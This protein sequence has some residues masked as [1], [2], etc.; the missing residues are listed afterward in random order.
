[1]RRRRDIARRTYF[2]RVTLGEVGVDSGLMEF[3]DG[4]ALEL[5]DGSGNPIPD[6]E[7]ILHCA[8][9]SQK[10]GKLDREG[11]AQENNVPPGPVVVE[12]VEKK[13]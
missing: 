6:A 11:K 3:K 12:F 13:K 5:S 2:F 7:Y 8:D 9:G 4:I 1:M 10:K